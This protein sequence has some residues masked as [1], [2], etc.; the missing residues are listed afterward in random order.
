MLNRNIVPSMAGAQNDIR[1]H[2]LKQGRFSKEVEEKR[3]GQ[4]AKEF[5]RLFVEIML[6]SMRQNVPESPLFGE[7][8]AREIFQDMLD[9][10]YAKMMVERRG[11]GISEAMVK[12]MGN[13]L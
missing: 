5:E 10:E 1:L 6:K 12:Q 8:N 7:S 4:A 2:T 9:G 3:L 11:F 13:K